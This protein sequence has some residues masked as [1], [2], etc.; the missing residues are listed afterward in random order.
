MGLKELNTR[1]TTH[2]ARN[3]AG[4]IFLY[5]QL[6]DGHNL[7]G[8]YHNAQGALEGLCFLA[9]P[10]EVNTNSYIVKRERGVIGLWGEREVTILIATPQ[11]TA[12]AELYHLIAGNHLALSHV[13]LV[14]A[15]RNL[16]A[17][18]DTYGNVG[19]FLH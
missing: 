16:L 15:E 10:M 8:L 5:G 19:L 12:I 2:L 17:A 18:H 7:I 6:V 9:L 3:H 1:G 13:R 4:K 11:D 14:K